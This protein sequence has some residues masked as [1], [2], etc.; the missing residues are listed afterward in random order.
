MSA[1]N[2]TIH[3]ETWREW[4]VTARTPEYEKHYDSFSFWS[5]SDDPKMVYEELKASVYGTPIWV[6]N[7]ILTGVTRGDVHYG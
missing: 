2:Y 4:R 7:L 6:C 1:D 3:C 5:K